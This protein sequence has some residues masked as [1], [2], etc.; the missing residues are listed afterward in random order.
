MTDDSNT[1]WSNR[2]AII[3]IIV[4]FIASLFGGGYSLLQWVDNRYIDSERFVTSVSR[5]VV[6]IYDQRI[7]DLRHK[8]AFLL[9]F[10][11]TRTDEIEFIRAQIKE[12]KEHRLYF[13]ETGHYPIGD[14]IILNRYI[15]KKQLR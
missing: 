6:A 3:A 12:I 8:E 10:S 7:I 11:P 14:E 15:L 1:D 13:L 2:L 9:E 5:T 4:S